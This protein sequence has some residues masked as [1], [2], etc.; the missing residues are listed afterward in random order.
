MNSAGFQRALASTLSALKRGLGELLESPPVKS[1]KSWIDERT[2]QARLQAAQLELKQNED[3]FNAARQKLAEIQPRHEEAVHDLRKID[4]KIINMPQPA[5]QEDRVEYHKVMLEMHQTRKSLVDKEARLA[6]EKEKWH[7]EESIAF[8]RFL[9]SL[10]MT[11]SVEQ[12][13]KD[14]MRNV[15]VV[16]ST[17]GLFLP[18]LIFEP[19]KMWRLRKEFRNQIENGAVRYEQTIDA[20]V[21]SL[22]ASLEKIE[23]SV[24][25]TQ[26]SVTELESK[27]RQAE[28]QASAQVQQHQ[29]QDQQPQGEDQQ[30]SQS[31][32]QSGWDQLERVAQENLGLTA[33]ETIA[34]VCC[35][36]ATAIFAFR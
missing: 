19:I 33:T 24:T 27:A 30:Q 34:V 28:E 23:Q 7:R 16:S 21:L 25:S 14:Q 35:V 18:T 15:T 9:Q 6:I 36:V 22:S 20:K 8:D 4:T 29:Q 1:A 10:R 11:Y 5:D 12:W 3:L 13:V 31:Q 17:I 2:G 32:P 26:K